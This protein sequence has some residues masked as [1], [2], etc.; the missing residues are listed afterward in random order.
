MARYKAVSEAVA[1][2]KRQTEILRQAM[3]KRGVTEDEKVAV[4]DLNKRLQAKCAC[5]LDANDEII[6]DRMCLAHRIMIDDAARA[7]SKASKELLAQ[8]LDPIRFANEHNS[9]PDLWADLEQ[10]IEAFTQ[11]E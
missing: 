1:M 9:P 6:A 3:E 4:A 10:R 11:R 7:A 2:A 8:A 5:V